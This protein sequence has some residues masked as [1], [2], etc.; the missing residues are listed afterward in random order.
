[1]KTVRFALSD[2]ED[3]LYRCILSLLAGKGQPEAQL[4]KKMFLR[5][6]A[7]E[8]VRL[9]T[10]KWLTR[11]LKNLRRQGV[12]DKAISDALRASLPEGVQ[13]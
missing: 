8:Q 12:P 9:S 1:M 3:E 2:R 10:Y 13:G 6:L 7:H 11:F 4:A 5:G